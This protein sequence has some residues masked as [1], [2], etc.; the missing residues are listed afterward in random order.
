MFPGSGQEASM[1]GRPY[2]AAG[3]GAKTGAHIGAPLQFSVCDPD[4]CISPQPTPPDEI[5]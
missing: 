4:H 3:A 5:P 2:V 1:Y